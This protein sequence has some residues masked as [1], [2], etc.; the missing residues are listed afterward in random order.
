MPRRSLAELPA[1][2]QNVVVGCLTKDVD[3]GELHPYNSRQAVTYLIDWLDSIEAWYAWIRGIDP[4]NRS[5]VYP[6][7]LLAIPGFPSLDQTPGRPWRRNALTRLQAGHR[8]LQL[9]GWTYRTDDGVG[10]AG[11]TME[12]YILV[13]DRIHACF[14]RFFEY[15]NHYI[16]HHLD[17][18]H[19]PVQ[20]AIIDMVTQ[21]Y[22]V[23]YN[24]AAAMYDYVSDFYNM[25]WGEHM[26]RAPGGE[27][28]VGNMR[29]ADD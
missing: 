27:R 24:N 28:Y 16:E 11:I 3:H 22:A 25:R 1:E 18:M 12:E 19:D 2:V 14:N 15:A 7:E 17:R 23:C 9:L 6:D 10:V 13:F 29:S 26:R 20:K 8:M 4:R 5:A 21:D